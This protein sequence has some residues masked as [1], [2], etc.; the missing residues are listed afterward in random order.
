MDALRVV[1]LNEIEEMET[2]QRERFEV[3]DLN[4]ANWVFRKLSAINEKNKEIDALAEAER[5][6]ITKWQEE[7]KKR[8]ESNREYLESLLIKYYTE[9]KAKDDKFKLSTPFGSISARKQAAKFIYD[10]EKLMTFLKE[11]NRSEWIRIKEEIDK[12][13]LKKAVQVSGDVVVD[14]NGE[15]IDGITIEDQ[16]VKLSVKLTEV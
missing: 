9:E 5:E 14:E 6:R 7:E 8:N 1:E 12:V 13:S 2:E 4:S 10:E 11:N 16:G 15:I 3:H